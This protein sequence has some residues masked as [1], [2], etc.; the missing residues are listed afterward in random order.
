M[1]LTTGEDLSFVVWSPEED[2]V[3]EVFFRNLFS[4]LDDCQRS[5]TS[6]SLPQLLLFLHSHDVSLALPGLPKWL[7]K[8]VSKWGL[9]FI[10]GKVIGKWLLGYQS[11]Y[12]EYVNIENDK[13]K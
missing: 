5:G 4:Y 2:G 12:K 3:E 1:D 10:G 13:T 8:V 7:G 6:P 11:S 9:G